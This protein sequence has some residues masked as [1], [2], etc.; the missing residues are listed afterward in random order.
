MS[1]EN[2]NG[3]PRPDLEDVSPE[4]T[5]RVDFLTDPA[6]PIEDDPDPLSSWKIREAGKP[7]TLEQIHS[8]L[9][10]AVEYTKAAIEGTIKMTADLNEA[11]D[12][13]TKQINIL[14]VKAES[15]SQFIHK[16]DEETAKT[17]KMLDGV[18]RDVQF[19]KD[20]VREIKV[21]ARQAASQLPAIK[22]LLGEILARLP[23]PS[24]PAPEPPPEIHESGIQDIVGTGTDKS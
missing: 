12:V 17:A 13:R 15:S 16:L 24:K 9:I 1:A 21:D 7:V 6:P 23:D 19:M 20:D 3:K 8:G 2:G 22:E 5:L 4:P 10:A 14:S 18:R 11:V